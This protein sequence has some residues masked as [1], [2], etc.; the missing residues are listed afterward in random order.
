MSRVCVVGGGAAGMIAAIVAARN[1]HAVTLFEKNEK[2]GKKIYITGKGRCNLTNACE[3]E[4]LFAKV[5]SNSRFLYSAFYSFTNEDT[6]QFLQDIGLKIKVERGNRVFPESDHASDVISVLAKECTRCGVKIELHT[7]V[8]RVV[9]EEGRVCGVELTGKKALYEADACIVATGGLSYPTTG[10]TGDGYRFAKECG[11]TVTDCYPSLVAIRLK[12]GFIGD[13]QGL[14]LKNVTLTLK[15]GKK[16]LYEDMG[17]M[18]FTADGISGPLVLSASS[19][20]AGKLEKGESTVQLDLKPAMTK[21]QLDVRLVRDFEEVKNKQY[22]NALDKLL[23]QKLIGVIISLSGIEP[24]K[25]VNQI[26]KEERF[27]LVELLK[28]LTLH[29]HSLG[30]YKEAVITKGGVKVKEVNPSTM[31]S[32]LVNGLYFA[33]EVL[34]VDAMTGGYNLQIAWSTGYVAGNSI[35]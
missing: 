20:L 35:F 18:L 1:G 4:E 31:E 12:E 32:K 15:Q 33:G 29:V 14:S 24:E 26:T 30:G 9:C 10:S 6:M 22:K 7:E 23:P 34:D 21:E 17:E 27:C 3:M 19:Y 8:K 13:L 25:Q 2:L 16:T 11:H 5:M 28:H